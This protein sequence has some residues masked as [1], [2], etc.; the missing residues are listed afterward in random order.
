MSVLR[1]QV[2]ETREIGVCSETAR[3]TLRHNDTVQRSIE[4]LP[5]VRA[6]EDLIEYHNMQ[7]TKASL[8][9]GS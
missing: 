1:K 8:G 5:E 3:H 6:L 7:S 9:E 2:G 4:L